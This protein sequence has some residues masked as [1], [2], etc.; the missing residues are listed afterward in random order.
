[1]THQRQSFSER[2][3]VL[4]RFA[5]VPAALLAFTLLGSGCAH[6]PPPRVGP[7]PVCGK[8]VEL[9]GRSLKPPVAPERAADA[10]PQGAKIWKDSEGRITAVQM[11]SGGVL[12][13]EYDQYGKVKLMQEPTGAVYA[14]HDN[15]RNWAGFLTNGERSPF[16]G[17]VMVGNDY[18]VRVLHQDGSQRVYNPS[19][20]VVEIVETASF[21]AVKEIT[22]PRGRVAQ[23]DYDAGGEPQ[24]IRTFDRSVLFKKDGKWYSWAPG[25]GSAVEVQY[26]IERD[27]DGS[28]TVTTPATVTT[29]SVSGMRVE[30]ND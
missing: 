11:A 1:M 12:L 8:A 4:R 7:D 18:T 29:Y 13:L 15:C 16:E 6:V 10:E 5:L 20:Y 2:L 17:V 25:W 23:F 9:N 24:T 27:E 21:T 30:R 19:G 28:V 26:S 3:I 22:D 14:R